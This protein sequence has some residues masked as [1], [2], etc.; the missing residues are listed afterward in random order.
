[1]K[2]RKRY[3]CPKWILVAV[4]ILEFLTAAFS[5]QAQP[6]I[7]GAI[8][9]TDSWYSNPF[10]SPEE[11]HFV[12]CAKVHGSAPIKVEAEDQN[13]TIVALPHDWENWYCKFVEDELSTGILT[14]TAKDGNGRIAKKQSNNLDHIRRIKATH[15]IRFSNQTISPAIFWDPIVDADKYYV[16]IYQLSTQ[17]EV[18][19]SPRLK[20]TTYQVPGNI[21]NAGTSYVFRILAQNYD[22]CSQHASGY[23]LENRSSTWS[24]DFTPRQAK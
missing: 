15:N 9:Y 21:L 18:F 7:E 24:R 19:R 6:V 5:V 2:M 1:M 14:I 11:H 20:T 10:G 12:A 3:I 8:Y 4:I 13:G 22:V 16:R 23:C 17:K